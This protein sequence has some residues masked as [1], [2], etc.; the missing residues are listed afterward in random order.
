MAV[1]VKLFK[2]FDKLDDIVYEPVKMI[3]DVCRQPLKNAD[4]ANERKMKETEA[5]LQQEMEKFEVDLDLKRKSGE[6]DI[7]NTNRRI[8]AEIDNMIAQNELERNSQVVEAIKKYQEDLGR[9][10][11]ELAN[12]IG[13]MSVELRERTQALV[14][15]KTKEYVALQN[16]VQDRAANRLME[17]DKQFPNGGRAKE[18]MENSVEKQ[19]TSILDRTDEFMK[20]MND[21]IANLQQNINEIT[22][23]AVKNTD[24]YLDPMRA[25]VLPVSNQDSSKLS[26]SVQGYIDHK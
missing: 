1:L 18:I 2:M 12:S 14:I 3:C 4:A 17:F 7:A 16:E 25:Q 5:R 19:L 11:V 13:K 26:S 10:S 8:N 6:M 9:V 22:A 24:K 23:Q 15:E 20:S 21:D